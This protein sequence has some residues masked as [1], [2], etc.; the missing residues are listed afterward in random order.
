M[1]HDLI[2]PTLKEVFGLYF[3]E[4]GFISITYLHIT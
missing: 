1:I 3:K 2:Y 4:F